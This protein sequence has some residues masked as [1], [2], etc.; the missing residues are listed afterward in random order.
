MI[1][2]NNDEEIIKGLHSIQLDHPSFDAAMKLFLSY[3]EDFPIVG[4]ANIIEKIEKNMTKGNTPRK[5]LVKHKTEYAIYTCPSHDKDKEFGIYHEQN[6][7][8][9]NN[10]DPH[11]DKHQPLGSVGNEDSPIIEPIS[12]QHHGIDGRPCGANNTNSSPNVLDNQTWIVTWKQKILPSQPSHTS[13]PRGQMKRSAIAI[14]QQYT[15]GVV[16]MKV[17]PIQ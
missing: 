11:N 6:H 3:A 1:G 4:V 17:A 2:L 10:L 16:L 7:S 9:A 13:H 15:P 5:Y 12:Q 14:A 8:I